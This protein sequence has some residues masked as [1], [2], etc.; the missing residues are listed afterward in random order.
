MVVKHVFTSL[1]DGV[2]H[3]VIDSVSERY[4]LN[5]PLYMQYLIWLKNILISGDFGNSYQY[6]RSVIETISVYL[7]ATLELAVTSFLIIIAIGIPVGIYAAYR[8]NKIQDHIIRVIT[9]LG[10]S[11][12][13]FWL[14]LI[15]IIVFSLTL[16][17]FPTSGYGGI[18]N[19]ILPAITL[20]VYTTCLII[21][22]MRTSTLEIFTKPFIIY[23][24]A[25]GLPR[26]AI[27]R[28]HIL[29]NA[30]LP[31]ITVL[32]I[33]FGHLL[34][35]TMIIETVFAWPGIGSLLVSASLARDIPLVTGLILLIVTL[36]LI[37]NL[38]VDIILH[39]I[40]PRI[41]YE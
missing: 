1:E 32:G 10:I 37:I 5:D 29:R 24:T 27:T 4:N 38:I 23:A 20:S 17:W 39:Y 36:V 18:E 34:A 19:L 41:R 11:F 9:I 8:E 21:R 16:R 26:F 2:S 13:S 31:V 30:I 14:G 6:N 28:D 25:K 12:P 3:E 35:G 33:Q 7:P 40:D 22:L 15:L